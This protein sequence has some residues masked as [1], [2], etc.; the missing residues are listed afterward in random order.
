MNSV[1]Y[2]DIKSAAESTI[3]D[4][5][6][7]ENKSL[8]ITGSTGSIGSVLVN[9]FLFRNKNY[10]QN[11]KLLLVVRDADKAKVLFGTDSNIV[12]IQSSVENLSDDMIKEDIDFVIHG[13]SPTKSKFFIDKP[14]ET[15]DIAYLGTKKILEISARKNVKSFV[16]MSSM[17]MYGVI[18]AEKETTEN[19]LGYIDPLDIRSSYSEG[20]R[21]CELMVYSYFK[22]YSVPT[23]IARIAQTFGAGISQ[24]ETR[25]YKYF[26]DCILNGENIVLKSSG[27][28]VINF[29]Y[30]TDTVL[31]I[32]KIL[33]D[34]ERG[35]AYNI[36]AEP[37]NMTVL[38]CAKWLVKKYGNN[39]QTVTTQSDMRS[40]SGLAPNN[41]MVLSNNKL[42]ELGWSCSYTIQ[43]TYDRL[44]KYFREFNN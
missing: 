6:Q 7:F 21:L 3:I 11:T 27:T 29:C 9:V 41:Q 4:W 40:S 26:T 30:T 34:G 22:E 2:E 24:N 39:N 33:L 44:I 5:K 38:D 12:Y 19:D 23:K 13:A 36:S 15:L 35:E 10:N 43:D 31:G 8:L 28:T 20:K 18:E 25:I 16:Y 42:K 1:L 37:T 17:E 14:V 32:L